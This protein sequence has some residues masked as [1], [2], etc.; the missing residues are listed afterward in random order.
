MSVD[1]ILSHVQGNACRVLL[2][3]LPL[4]LLFVITFMQGIYHCIPETKHISR[5]YSGAATL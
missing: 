2:L 4:L 5:V 1:L 3:L